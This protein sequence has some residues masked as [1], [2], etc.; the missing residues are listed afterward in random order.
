MS[1][2]A[3]REFLR[4]LPVGPVADDALVGVL[5]D[6]W[7]LLDRDDTR[8]EWFKLGRL[9]APSW[10]GSVLRFVAE[11]HG[12]TTLGSTRAELQH[13]EVDPAAGTAQVVRSTHRQLYA[14]APRL[15]VRPLADEVA[16]LILDGID[17]A[18][19]KWSAD[20]SVVTVRIGTIIP[21]ESAAQ[22]TVSGRRRRFKAALDERLPGRRIGS[23]KYSRHPAT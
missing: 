20:R 13:W 9:E 18:R 16:A 10:D 14:M 23:W 11:R 2:E 22:Q 21:A 17:D 8:M 15:D 3:L 19:L 12:W 5:A 4:V 1:V 7:D 6:A